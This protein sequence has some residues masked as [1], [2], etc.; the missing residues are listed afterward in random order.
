MSYFV[1]AKLGSMRKEVEW[2][3][4]PNH[5]KGEK[6]TNIF[7][8]ADRRCCVIDTQ[9]KVGLLSKPMNYPRRDFCHPHFGG[10]VIQVSQEFIDECLRKQPQSGDVIHGVCVIA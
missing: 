3:V 5:N 10:E 1:K 6:P 7:I 2:V 4:Y 8:Q 9:T